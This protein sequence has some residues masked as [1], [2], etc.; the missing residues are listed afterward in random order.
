MVGEMP[1]LVK[2]SSSKFQSLKSEMHTSL[3]NLRW[4]FPLK[5]VSY[6][7]DL[8]IYYNDIFIIFIIIR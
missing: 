7:N 4:A 8:F 2:M 6:E 3:R 1:S 5:W